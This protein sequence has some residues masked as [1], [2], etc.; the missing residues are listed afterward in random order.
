MLKSVSSTEISTERSRCSTR[1]LS[2]SDRIGNAFSG[3]PA[4]PR[5]AWNRVSSRLRGRC[6]RSWRRS[7]RRMAWRR[8][9]RSS[10]CPCGRGSTPATRAS[11][12]DC[13]AA[14]KPSSSV[15]RWKASS[16][17]SAEWTRCARSRR[18]RRDGGRLH[19]RAKHL[20]KQVTRDGLSTLPDLGEHNMASKNIQHDIVES[21]PGRINVMVEVQSDGSKKKVELPLRLLALGD[22]T[23]REDATPIVEREAININKDNFDGVLK[24]LAV[25]AD[26]AVTHG[27]GADAEETSVHLEFD[28]LSDFHPEAV[29]R[30]VPAIYRL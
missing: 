10:R 17:G 1:V 25:R 22:Y 4:W 28:K 19:E 23:G 5:S 8:G 16:D 24:S 9:N 11:P 27:S 15:G 20:L 6:W 7:S 13:R 21:N 3:E 2:T 29:A 30:Q 12:R 18:R 14:P 26:Y